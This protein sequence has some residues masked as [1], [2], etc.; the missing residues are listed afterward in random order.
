MSSS[1]SAPAGE[2]IDLTN[3]IV[4]YLPSSVSED[5][6]RKLFEPYGPIERVKLMTDKRTGQSASYGFVKF[7]NEAD[8]KRAIEGLNGKPLNGK[9][10]R[11][12]YSRP[13]SD[14]SIYVGNFLE[15]VTSDELRK[16]FEPYGNILDVKILTDPK[17][18]KSRGCGFVRFEKR[19]DGMDA[20][21]G[22]KD[23]ALA[24]F[25]E[26]PLTVRVAQPHTKQQ[27]H[28]RRPQQH[29][30]A[31]PAAE[32]CKALFVYGLPKSITEDKVE[33]I[34]GSFG[35][36]E[37]TFL[38]I[39]DEDGFHSYAI[40]TF[41]RVED[42]VRAQKGLNDAPLFGDSSKVQVSF[43]AGGAK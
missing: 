11:V 21:G 30:H 13:H 1:D 42:A 33:S 6:L 17:T 20:I 31:K 36:I 4:N 43:K 18:G 16:R 23:A 34:F 9:T 26:K 28:H 10:L 3:L 12:D 40:V 39:S 29:Q 41:A 25:C 22:M 8:A 15:T 19:S 14:V 37:K 5:S 32:P 7:T 27:D 35:A 2:A 38:K 24:G